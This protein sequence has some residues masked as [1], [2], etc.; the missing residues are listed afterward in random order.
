MKFAV[1]LISSFPNAAA[2]PLQWK[3]FLR[4]SMRRNS[5][6]SLRIFFLVFFCCP[7]A[8]P[9]SF[10]ISFVNSRRCVLIAVTE[11]FLRLIINTGCHGIYIVRKG[12]GMQPH[13]HNKYSRTQSPN[14]ISPDRLGARAVFIFRPTSQAS[15]ATV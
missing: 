14:S 13:S 15:H 4:L 12:L 10:F 3:S 9:F 1:V 11:D 6:R 7:L 2:S 8:Y 5:W